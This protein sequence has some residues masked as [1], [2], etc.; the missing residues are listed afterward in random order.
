MGET[1]WDSAGLGRDANTSS[2]FTNDNFFPVASFIHSDIWISCVVLRQKTKRAPRGEPR[3]EFF[4]TLAQ[5]TD[6]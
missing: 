5:R 2:A 3:S 6:G 1:D 4:E